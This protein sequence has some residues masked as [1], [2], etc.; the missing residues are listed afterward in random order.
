MLQEPLLG[1]GCVSGIFVVNGDAMS[2]FSGRAST[3]HGAGRIY[4]LPD[5]LKV[6]Y[7]TARFNVGEQMYALLN[8]PREDKPARLRRLAENFNFFG[9]PAAIF[10]YVD[11]QMGPPPVSDLGMF[12]QSFMLLATEAGYG[13]C[14]Q[15]AWANR[16]QTVTEFIEADP[17]LICF[18]A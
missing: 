3:Q 9:A 10:C 2:R 17:S 18:V 15:E 7:R 1:A 4:R 5:R 6:L 12:L 16:A 13:T 14:A 11:C 8:I